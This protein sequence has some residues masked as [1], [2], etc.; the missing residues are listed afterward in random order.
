[1]R[2]ER[3]HLLIVI[4]A[5]VALAGGAAPVRAQEADSPAVGLRMVAD[6]FTSPVALVEAP[7]GSGRRRSSTCGAGSS[8]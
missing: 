8:R 2:P 3:L 7:D 5:T 1:M 4:C 6:G